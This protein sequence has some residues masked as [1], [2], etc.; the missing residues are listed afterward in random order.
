MLCQSILGI[1][2]R[3]IVEDYHKSEKFLK[4]KEESAA[5]TTISKTEVKGKINKSFF[6]GSP[7]E[8]MISTIAFIKD[9]Y[10]SYQSYLDS[11]GFGIGWRE[12]FTTAILART[13]EDLSLRSRL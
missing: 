1:D 9:R 7:E 10:G 3:T 8:A 11:I 4:K 5:I 2:D 13:N 6:S 12:R